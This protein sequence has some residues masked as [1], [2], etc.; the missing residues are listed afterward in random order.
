MCGGADVPEAPDPY[1]TAEAQSKYNIE[2]AKAAAGLNAVDQY[3]PM[4]STT[5][6]RNP[7][8]TPKSQT[9]ALSPEV[10][11]WLNAQFGS[12]TK[13]QNATS[14]Q[15]DFLPQDKFA[16]PTGTDARGYASQAFGEGVI[17]PA[18]FDASK[19]AQT[20]YDAQKARFEPDLADSKKQKEV[21]LSQRGIPVGSDIWE[22]EMSRQDRTEGDLYSQAS[23]QAELD[24]GAEQTRRTNQATQALNFGSNQYQTDVGNQLLERSRPYEEA[25]ALMGTTPQ[26]STP[27]FMNTGQQ[28]VAAPDYL[29]AVNQ[30]YNQQMAQYQANQANQQGMMKSIGGIAGTIAAMSD[31]NTKEDRESA[32]GE[33]ILAAFRGLP[34]DDYRYKDEAQEAY[35]LPEHRTGPMAQD[36]ARTFDGDGRTVDIGDAVGK[37]I[38]AVKALD[39]R[40]IRRAA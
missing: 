36:Y 14:K 38:A 32:D 21:E 4:G 35:G 8:G 5:Y 29:G 12:A 24:A 28:N 10:E 2:A 33:A 15:L 13:L 7:D 40:D 19:I 1:A 9:V 26:F 30:N 6:Q 16:L 17:D 34:V 25:A 11:Q 22:K 31:E 3:G 27:S 23:R 18:S 39:Q 37:L 20:S